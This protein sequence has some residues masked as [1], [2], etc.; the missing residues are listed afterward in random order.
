MA[1]LDLPAGL[2]PLGVDD[3]LRA[4][5]Q[6]GFFSRSRR[7]WWCDVTDPYE[8]GQTAVVMGWARVDDPANP[9][10]VRST[11]RLTL[12]TQAGKLEPTLWDWEGPTADARKRLTKAEACERLA[13][14]PPAAAVLELSIPHG[15]QELGADGQPRE[16][17]FDGLDPRP[18]LFD[19]L[20]GL[21]KRALDD[22]AGVAYIAF[23]D[24]TD[25]VPAKSIE[26][27]TW[28]AI[29]ADP[30]LPQVLEEAELT[31]ADLEAIAA[32]PAKQAPLDPRWWRWVNTTHNRLADA[33][34]DMAAVIDSV[35]PAL[36]RDPRRPVPI[37]ALNHYHRVPSVLPPERA[38]VWHAPPIGVGRT[39]CGVQ[40][41][42]NYQFLDAT[43]WDPATRTNAPLGKTD[44]DRFEADAIRRATSAL[45][46]EAPRAALLQCNPTS[47]VSG[48][49]ELAF[50]PLGL[51]TMRH[52]ALW[53]SAGLLVSQ[54][55]RPSKP[56]EVPAWQEYCARYQ[57][58]L[59]GVLGEVRTI[60]GP[61]EGW[62]SGDSFQDGE[63]WKTS[64]WQDATGKRVA[65]VTESPAAQAERV[66]RETGGT[67][68]DADPDGYWI[69]WEAGQA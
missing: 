42:K 61:R 34:G 15:L 62:T 1:F 8:H 51:E 38:G 40:V 21:A 30:L 10:P 5:V 27:G 37:L 63:R 33:I 26:R 6:T 69:A 45:A 39:P 25:F 44:W 68:L 3:E 57:T 18:Y 48:N 28:A 56:A 55:S 32:L 41:V 64:A 7:P 58:A 17:W 11:I 12:S 52:A 35:C 22:L 60:L 16:V 13:K 66:T 65:R 29:L 59:E 36:R 14:R 19:V 9:P 67:I 49:P 50:S 46:S 24:E 23:D 2:R 53:S 54:K 4:R 20:P 31:R 43:R 47:P